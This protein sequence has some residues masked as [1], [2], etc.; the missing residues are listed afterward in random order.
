MADTNETTS[1]SCRFLDESCFTQLYETFIEAFSDY[2]FPFALTEQQFRNHINLNGVDLTRTVGCYENT[3]LVGFSLNGF[4]TWD[5]V[6]TVYDAGTGVIPSARRRGISA[7]MFETMLPVFRSEGVKQFLLEVITTNTAAIRL[8][9]KLGFEHSRELALMQ[10]DKVIEHNESSTIV[11]VREIADPD[12]DLMASFWSGRPSWQNSV[13]AM[14]RSLTLKTILGAF[15]DDE[16]VGYVASS[17]NYGRIAQMAVS[18]THRHRGIGK[19]LLKRIQ[20]MT[21]TGYSL[22]IINID[23]SLTE[24]IGFF[25]KCGFYERL[26]Q[27]EMMARI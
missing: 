18:P 26:A 22:Q 24:T 6:S 13:A 17:A 3:R 10:C 12:W 27:H 9:E 16:L 21:T 20:E 8:Y 11:E 2:V 25:E 15:V 7:A 5:G 4:G 1:R 14:K 19:A 23:K